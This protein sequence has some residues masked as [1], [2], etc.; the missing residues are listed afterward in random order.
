MSVWEKLVSLLREQLLEERQ[1]H[2]AGE[3]AQRL[4][5]VLAQQAR[6]QVRL[7][8]A[9][10][11]AR[12][13]LARAEGRQG[14]TPPMSMLPAERAALDRDLDDDVAL[15]GHPR[16]HLEVHADGPVRERRQRLRRR[17]ARRDRGEHGATGTGT[18][19]PRFSVSFWPSVPRSCGLASS[20]VRESRREEPHHGRRHREVEVRGTD[21]RVIVFRLNG[22]V[23]TPPPSR[24]RR[25]AAAA[26]AA[27]RGD[28]SGEK[29]RADRVLRQVQPVLLR[30]RRGSPRGS[31]RRR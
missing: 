11:E 7:A 1:V 8:F 23:P 14:L 18:S 24:C 21:A 2:D 29:M 5:F 12:G 25:R 3:T 27:A 9:Q 17:A 4:A 31:R 13:H 6:E 19:S 28:T 10:A 20:R 26:A 15:V 30:P 22:G 16:R